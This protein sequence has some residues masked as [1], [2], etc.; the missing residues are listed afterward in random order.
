MAT[1]PSVSDPESHHHC[2]HFN[3]VGE[4][5]LREVFSVDVRDCGPEL[6]AGESIGER[7]LAARGDGGPACFRRWTSASDC[8]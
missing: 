6:L 7:Q 4:Y 5:L 8:W 1:T 3:S 2:Y